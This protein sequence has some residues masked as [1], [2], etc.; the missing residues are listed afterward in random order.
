MISYF[1]EIKTEYVNGEVVVHIADTGVGLEPEELEKLF[2]FGK[3]SSNGTQ[4]EKGTGL[5]LIISKEFVSSNNGKIFASH[6]QPI[7]TVFSFSLPVNDN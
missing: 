4:G 3:N 5:G 1:N 7:G 6:N 2:D